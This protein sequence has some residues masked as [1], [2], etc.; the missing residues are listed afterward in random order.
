[1]RGDF[2]RDSFDP[3]KHYSQVLQ[4][5]GRVQVDAD[6]NEQGAILLYYMRALAR[7]L[8][9]PHGGPADRLGFT[10]LTDE[11]ALLPLPAARLSCL[12]AGLERGEFLI[13]AGRYYVDGV[14]VENDRIIA[15]GEQPGFSEMDRRRLRAA[16]SE[17]AMIYL[18]VW[19]RHVTCIEDPDIRE[20]ALGG[21]DTA[22]RAQIVWQVKLLLHS[23]I[24][25]P[26]EPGALD[27]LPRLGSGMLRARA[28]AGYR[29]AENRLYRVEIHRSGLAGHATFK[30]SRDNGSVVFPVSSLATTDATHATLQIGRC[31]GH[32]DR[33]LRVGDVVELASDEQARANRSDALQ[34]V[35]AVDGTGGNSATVQVA[36]LGRSGGRSTVMDEDAHKL[37][38]LWNQAPA[39]TE[40]G[41]PSVAEESETV[42]GWIELEEGIEV[43]FAKGGAYRAGDYWLIPARPAGGGIEWPRPTDADG[44]CVTNSDGVYQLARGP[45]HGY[46]PLALRRPGGR[47]EDCRR[48]IAW[49]TAQ[50]GGRF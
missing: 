38:R 29:G 28:H 4:Q 22:T 14:P 18:D 12:R 27:K 17:P 40:D 48:R 37:L 39:A 23:D 50:D 7:D 31:L 49:T 10:I 45:V 46:A 41:A 30:W 11:S 20:P 3:H 6:W 19:E 5:Q 13:G 15:Y 26:P 9:G 35:K 47:F 32:A 33:L 44:H 8:I 21:T 36:A 43:Q 24:G 34:V 2:S 25:A 1:M 16:S 42:Q